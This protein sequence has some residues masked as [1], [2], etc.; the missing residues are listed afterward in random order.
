MCEI[1]GASDGWMVW[2]NPSEAIYDLRFTIYDLAAAH[3]F[4]KS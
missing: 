3:D 2:E 4:R 1:A